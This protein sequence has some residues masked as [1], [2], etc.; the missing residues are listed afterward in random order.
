MCCVWLSWE[1]VLWGAQQDWRI[2]RM[3]AVFLRVA[4]HTFSATVVKKRFCCAA[5]LQNG[6]CRLLMWM[7]G[8]AARCAGAN[9]QA[10]LQLLLGDWFVWSAPQQRWISEEF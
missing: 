1:V 10:A 2:S 5:C 6:S 4:R 8:G 7:I 3:L 9:P